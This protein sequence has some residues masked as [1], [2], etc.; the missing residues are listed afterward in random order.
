MEGWYLDARRGDWG[1]LRL[2][3]DAMTAPIKKPE[4]G[5]LIRFDHSDD[6]FGIGV[7]PDAQTLIT[8][9]HHGRLVVGPLAACGKF[10]LY[11]L[12]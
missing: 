9:R 4:A 10:N 5:A 2:D 12:K 11:C 6:S 1:L 7:L 3:W 8:V